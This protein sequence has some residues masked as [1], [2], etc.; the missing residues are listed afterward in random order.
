M[1]ESPQGPPAIDYASPDDE[2]RAIAECLIYLEERAIAAGFAFPGH[3]IGVAAQAIR[4]GMAEPLQP[5]K[6]A[7]G[8]DAHL[9][10]LADYRPQRVIER[11]TESRSGNRAIAENPTLDSRQD[12]TPSDE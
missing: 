4:D 6:P 10:P 5:P 9:I 7:D 11:V 3:L 8:R 2:A 12:R 1:T